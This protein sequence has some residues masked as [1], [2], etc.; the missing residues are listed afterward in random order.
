MVLKSTF[1]IPNPNVP[2]RVDGVHEADTGVAAERLT[3]MK[4]VLISVSAPN[5]LVAVSVIV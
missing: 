1:V 2:I 3:V 5:E 4:E